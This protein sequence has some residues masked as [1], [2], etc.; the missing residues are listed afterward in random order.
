MDRE[1]ENDEEVECA[2]AD[3]VRRDGGAGVRDD[4]LPE[5]SRAGDGRLCPPRRRRHLPVRAAAWPAGPDPIIIVVAVLL[6]NDSIFLIYF[7][8]KLLNLLVELQQ[9]LVQK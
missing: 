8:Y 5:D 3:A 1:N 6:S 9:H 2:K 4:L 7:S